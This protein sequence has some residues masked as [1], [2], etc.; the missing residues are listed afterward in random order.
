MKRIIGSISFVVGDFRLLFK[1]E[2]WESKFRILCWLTVIN[3][4]FINFLFQVRSFGIFS[5]SESDSDRSYKHDMNRT[6]ITLFV[7]MKHCEWSQ[8]ACRWLFQ[9]IRSRLNCFEKVVQIESIQTT[10]TKVHHNNLKNSDIEKIHSI[11]TKIQFSNL[12][13]HFISFHL[14]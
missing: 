8:K 14:I 1:S 7:C 13:P 3:L 10:F 12:R 4:G 9:T 11:H 6:R 5:E 2:F